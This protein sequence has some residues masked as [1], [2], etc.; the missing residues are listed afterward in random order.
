MRRR[1]GLWLR[2]DG[3]RQR[4]DGSDLSQRWDPTYGA[5]MARRRSTLLAYI[6]EIRLAPTTRPYN[7]FSPDRIDIIWR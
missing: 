7:V 1:Q 6:S 2:Q 4:S 3:T 5:P